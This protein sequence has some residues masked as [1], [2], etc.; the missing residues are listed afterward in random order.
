MVFLW[1]GLKHIIIASAFP[2]D[3]RGGTLEY[4]IYRGEPVFSQKRLARVYM[5]TLIKMNKMS[6]HREYLYTALFQCNTHL[7]LKVENTIVALTGA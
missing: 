1:L 6:A 7:R 5:G 2:R 4:S 3:H